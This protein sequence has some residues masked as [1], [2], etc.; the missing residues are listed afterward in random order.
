MGATLGRIVN[1]Y[2]GLIEICRQRAEELEISRLSIDDLSGLASGFAGKVLGDRQRK[3][4][5]LVTLGPMLQVL[6][7]KLLIRQ[8][9]GFVGT[10]PTK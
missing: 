4:M 8:E 10:A 5:G 7:L 1:D 9:I 6:G 3:R 2:Q